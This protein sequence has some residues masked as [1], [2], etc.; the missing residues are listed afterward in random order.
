[1]NGKRVKELAAECGTTV[2]QLDAPVHVAASRTAQSI[3][4]RGL[5]AQ[6]NYLIGRLGAEQVGLLLLELRD[7]AHQAGITNYNQEV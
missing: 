6:L 3:N 5:D 7:M 1:M 4:N 2:E